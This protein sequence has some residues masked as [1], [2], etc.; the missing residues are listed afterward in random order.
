MGTGEKTSDVPDIGES[1]ESVRK[2]VLFNDDFNTFDFITKSLIE[3]CGHGSMQAENC[4]LIAHC[5]GKCSV[6]NGTVNNLRPVYVEM[7]NRQITVEI[8]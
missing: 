3:V 2:L 1:T 5:K 6:K 4:A 8:C 7:T